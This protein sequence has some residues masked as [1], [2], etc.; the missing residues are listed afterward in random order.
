MLAHSPPLPLIIDYSGIDRD[1]DITAEDEEEIIVALEKR[2]RVRRVRFEVPLPNLQ[3][4][5]M[6]IEEEYP[7]LEYLVVERP[8]EDTSTTL[9]LPET[10]QAPHL[11]H[12]GLEGFALPIGSRLLTTAVGLITLVLVLKHPSSYFQPN[13]LLQWIS[14]M[15]QLETLHILFL[16]PVPNHDVERQLMQTPILTRVTLPNLR[17]FAFR[18]VSA[19][20]EAVVR[21]ITTPRLERFGIYFFEQLTFSIPRL[22]QFMNAAERISVSTVSNSSSLIIE[23]M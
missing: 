18:G 5:I 11:R 2:D 22:V 3:K 7:V 8:T 17:W 14:I 12:L 6:A 4:F 13:T 9:M 21:R 20:M 23:F 15:P 19:Y 10:F 16:F 1:I